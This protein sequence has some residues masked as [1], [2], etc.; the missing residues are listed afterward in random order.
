VVGS[1]NRYEQSLAARYCRRR[2]GGAEGQS[3][4]LVG[5]VSR[6]GPRVIE[7]PILFARE[8]FLCEEEF[9]GRALWL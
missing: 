2:L 7:R 6:K 5:Y 4:S 8:T 3:F 9:S 1:Y